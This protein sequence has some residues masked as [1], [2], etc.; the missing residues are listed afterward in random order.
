[1]GAKKYTISQGNYP[2][3]DGAKINGCRRHTSLAKDMIGKQP[4]QGEGRGGSNISVFPP[5]IEGLEK[6]TQ[7]KTTIRH[8]NGGGGHNHLL[9]SRLMGVCSAQ[10]EAM[11][12]EQ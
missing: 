9:V 5:A 7:K 12:V 4:R 1:V 6:N 8:Q 11:R 2:S 3:D 10:N